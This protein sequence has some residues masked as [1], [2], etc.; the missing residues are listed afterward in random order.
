MT[1]LAYER[2]GPR[3]EW[4]A[5]AGRLFRVSAAPPLTP[6]LLLTGVCPVCGHDTEQP[7]YLDRYEGV[8]PAAEKGAATPVPGT[9]AKVDDDLDVVCA[10]HV[11]HP[12]A[13]DADGCGRSWRLRVL[14]D[15]IAASVGAPRRPLGGDPSEVAVRAMAA[16]GEV[17]RVRAAADKWRASLTGLFTLVTA[18]L[19]LKG[20]D[21][22][23]GLRTAWKVAAGV[24]LLAGLAVTLWAGVRAARASFGPLTLVPNFDEQG[25]RADARVQRR[26]S[27]DAARKDLR[28]AVR[29]TV[30][31]LALLAAA[32]VV[33]WYGPAV[34]PA[35]RLRVTTE[36][37]RTACG[38]LLGS[39]AGRMLLRLPDHG[40]RQVPLADTLT[41]T[42]VDRCGVNTG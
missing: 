34:D 17:D 33:A 23:E 5:V 35:P 26:A 7:E 24:L 39:D 16:A 6:Y 14:W 22:V 13:E 29:A 40:V 41:V 8:L 21:S 18:S 32:V 10:C 20:R 31:A 1:E 11:V 28:T 15:G 30:A 37:G 25:H 12:G 2:V 42:P 19:V 4:G 38:E 36:D 27:A 3:A 9:P